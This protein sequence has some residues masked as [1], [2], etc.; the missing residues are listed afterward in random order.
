MMLC[1]SFLASLKGH[2]LQSLGVEA[3][4]VQPIKRNLIIHSTFEQIEF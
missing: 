1:S 4:E 3:I 2:S